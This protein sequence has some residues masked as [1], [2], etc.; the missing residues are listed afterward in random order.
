MIAVRPL[1]GDMKG[2]IDFGG[3]GNSHKLVALDDI[4]AGLR[5]LHQR[6]VGM[7]VTFALRPAHFFMNALGFPLEGAV[8]NPCQRRGGAEKS[9]CGMAVPPEPVPDL[10]PI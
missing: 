7:S 9:S 4:F 10:T 5:I 3:R 6:A 8:A 1:A 2:E